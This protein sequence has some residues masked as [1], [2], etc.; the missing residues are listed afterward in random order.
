VPEVTK[1]P[2]VK[3]EELNLRSTLAGEKGGIDEGLYCD[4]NVYT[5][6]FFC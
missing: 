1:T 6:A 5:D 4:I 2:K 3:G